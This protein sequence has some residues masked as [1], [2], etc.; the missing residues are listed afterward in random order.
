[1]E[2]IESDNPRNRFSATVTWLSDVGNVYKGYNITLTAR[3][4]R[5]VLQMM[6]VSL[7][8]GATYADD[9]YMDTYFSVSESDAERTGL[10][11][12]KATGGIRDFSVSP[13]VVV[14]LSRDWHVGAGMIYKRLLEDAKESPLVETVGSPDQIIAG[15]GIAYSW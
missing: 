9:N 11:I 14:H 4:W 10:N 2:F 5:E 15:A 1:V 13:V 6:D 3:F 12:F 7:G 8:V